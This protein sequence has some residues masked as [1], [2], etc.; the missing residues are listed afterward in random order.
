MAQPWR[1][2]AAGPD[3]AGRP[4]GLSVRITAGPG[5]RTVVQIAGRLDARAAAT[6]ASTLAA[7]TPPAR[8]GPPELA[9][10]LSGL[11]GIDGAG[12]QVL[13]DLQDRL[14]GRSG[15]LE[16]LSPTPAV[17]G[18]LHEADLHGTADLRGIDRPGSAPA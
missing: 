9:I 18:L 13:L 11:T 5:A 3:R 2:D 16:I 17:I 15:E 14:A 12:L 7:A 4:D 8:R 6:L 10:D 1:P